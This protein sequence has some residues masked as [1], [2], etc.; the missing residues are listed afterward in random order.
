MQASS[1][2]AIQ[3]KSWKDQLEASGILSFLYL[4]LRAPFAYLFAII[5]H[6]LT[7]SLH[8]SST[9]Q[10]EFFRRF[11][12]PI[13]SIPFTCQAIFSL[14]ELIVPG[15]HIPGFWPKIYAAFSI[16][17]W[18]IVADQLDELGLLF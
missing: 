17:G 7:I 3:C 16:R 1:L 13:V 5:G 12:L 8:Y 14:V 9:T 6:K 18:G 15:F 4:I 11:L 10:I 2:P